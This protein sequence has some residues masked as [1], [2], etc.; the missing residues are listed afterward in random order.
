M[1]TAAIIAEYN[2]FH[3]GHCRQIEETRRQ[4]KADYILA[5]MS[6]NFV[7]RGAPAFADKYLRARLALLGGADAVIELPVL[8]ATASA[9]FFAGGAVALL[10]QL[11]TVDI[12]SFGSES[13]NLALMTELA[14]LLAENQRELSLNTR[15][16]LKEGL[17]FPAAREHAFEKLLSAAS[18]QPAMAN[19]ET[20]EKR[21]ELSPLF[22]S[23]NNILGLEYC[24]ALY[25]SQSPIQPF[26]I[27]R[28][29]AGYHDAS[30][31]SAPSQI[32]SASAIRN[33][34]SRCPDS[35]EG[36]VPA[37]IYRSLSE[38]GLLSVPLTE[39]D[40]S[41]LLYY[42][43]LME[44]DQG[45]GDYLDCTRDLSDKICKNI[46]YFQ[47]FSGFCSRL[48]S[49]DLTYA[50]ISRVLIHI[51]LNLKT[52]GSFLPMLPERRLPAPYARLLGFRKSAAPLLGKI[53]KNS[54]IPL[55]TRLAGARRFLDDEAYGLLNS[56]IR[57]ATLYNRAASR[58]VRAP[59]VNEFQQSP[60]ILP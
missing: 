4:T 34:L 58:R 38:T 7:Q 13:G 45:F 17:S 20:E 3:N 53:K 48:K 1:K 37:A 2:P 39:D 11:N 22:S 49:K 26:T 32:A 41:E 30:L 42:K 16:F 36:Y 35:I 55:I 50:R 23:P 6:G 60:V 21:K 31:D 40:F 19:F 24:K 54:S 25:A 14:R 29:G 52:P 46:P 28:E 59:V 5:V 9:E 51:L 27:R 12:L 44:K 43:L 8:Y 18:F 56:D 15:A 47:N 57:C 10:N 33:A